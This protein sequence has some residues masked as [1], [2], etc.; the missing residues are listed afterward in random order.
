MVKPIG[1]LL[2]FWKTYVKARRLGF[3]VLNACL[4]ARVNSRTG[5]A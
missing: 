5:H 1:R 2:A 3:S 4:A